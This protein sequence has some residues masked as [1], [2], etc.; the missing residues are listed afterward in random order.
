MRKTSHWSLIYFIR[1]FQ[2]AVDQR[3][4]PD[5]PWLNRAAI[6][7]LNS[8]LK[9]DDIGIEWGSGRSTLWLA[10]RMRHLISI[11]HDRIWA[12][13]MKALIEQKRITNV[14]YHYFSISD[15]ATEESRPYVDVIST[16][17][18][19]SLQFALVDG[20]LRD[21]CALAAIDK[22]GPAG[23]LVIDNVERYLPSSSRSPESIDPKRSPASPLWQEFSQRVS[24]WR[25]VWVSNGVTDTCLWFKPC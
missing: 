4:Y 21:L 25:K 6:D 7:L 23:L 20:R 1:R 8:W 17:P 18:D 10:Q 2:L 22:L 16:V 5:D 19:S 9:S 14:A 11:E 13:R 24:D 3:R 15:A 12:E